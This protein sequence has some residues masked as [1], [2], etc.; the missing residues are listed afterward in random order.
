MASPYNVI[1]FGLKLE[2]YMP[3]MDGVE[4]MVSGRN[5]SQRPHGIFHFYEI[6]RI[7]KLIETKSGF[8]LARG[9]GVWEIGSD[10]NGYGVS[11]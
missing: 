2:W 8:V 3:Q 10:A 6:S 9:W 5:Q 4:N 7:G 11:F 1:L